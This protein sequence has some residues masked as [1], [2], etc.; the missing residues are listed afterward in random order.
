M[1]IKIQF[2]CLDNN[3]GMPKLMKNNYINVHQ[4]ESLKMNS[5][6]FESTGQRKMN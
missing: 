4:R 5:V 6:T 2:N 1:H 3:I